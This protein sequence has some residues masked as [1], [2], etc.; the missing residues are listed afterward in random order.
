MVKF[1]IKMY[2]GAVATADQVASIII[3]QTCQLVGVS[4]TH[5]GTV[6]GAVG[7][8]QWYQLA[9]QSTAQVLLNDSRN[10]IDEFSAVG[11]VAAGFNVGSNSP[12]VIP[13][14]KFAAGDKIYM[15][16]FVWQAF[17][18]SRLSVNLLFA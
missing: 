12:T 16:T 14:I 17:T 8:S 9:T 13:G 2:S 18:V 5:S 15:H 6:A 1:A 11:M 3:P 4:W 7:S 10:I